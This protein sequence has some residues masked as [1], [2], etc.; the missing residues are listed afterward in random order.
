[1]GRYMLFLNFYLGYIDLK[2]ASK[3]TKI[4]GYVGIAIVFWMIV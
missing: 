3:I 1:M 2:N 4:H